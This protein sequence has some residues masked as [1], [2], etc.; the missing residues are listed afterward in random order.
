M[1]D[2]RPEPMPIPTPNEIARREACGERLIIDDNG[3]LCWVR[4]EACLVFDDGTRMPFILDP[5]MGGDENDFSPG[6]PG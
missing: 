2:R 1:S 3:R 6:E 5:S 4:A